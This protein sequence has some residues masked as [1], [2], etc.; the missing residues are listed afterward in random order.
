VV[1]KAISGHGYQ[2][3]ERTIG[4]EAFSRPPDYDQSVD[5]VVR[6]TAGE[7]RKRLTQYYYE[8]GGTP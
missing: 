8:A 5:P 7:V 6:I 3:K 2:L 4:I 1:R